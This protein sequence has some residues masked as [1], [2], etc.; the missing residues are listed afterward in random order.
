MMS[1]VFST[2]GASALITAVLSSSMMVNRDN[3]R[4]VSQIIEQIESTSISLDHQSQ[5]LRTKAGEYQF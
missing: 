3:S 4:E 2:I 5:M 1:V